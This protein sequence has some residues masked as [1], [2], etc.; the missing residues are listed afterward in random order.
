MAAAG[1]WPL[2]L[3][4]HDVSRSDSVFLMQNSGT[5]V[6]AYLYLGA[7]HMVTGVD[8]LLYLAGVI[9]F[10][11][12]VRE[13]A[14]YAT[15]FALGHSTTLLVGVLGGVHAN[16]SLI[17]AVIGLSVAYK[18]FE[19]MGGFR[20]LG[21]QP[22]PR[23][24]VVIF[25]LFH[26]FGLA[27]KLQSYNLAPDGLV[28]NILS[29]NLGVELGQVVALTVMLTL[30]TLWR[31][32]GGFDRHAFAANWVLMTAGLVLMGIHLTEYF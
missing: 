7:K 25:G 23:A 4:A 26:G 6:L 14:L 17:D 13:V 12:R 24:A 3:A 32:Q 30:F 21:M 11:H 22:D 18:A 5:A 2:V 27:T 28:I 10:V 19:N 15:L 29:F 1:L 31:R 20:P 8:H 9:F 16:P